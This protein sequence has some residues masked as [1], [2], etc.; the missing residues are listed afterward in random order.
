M[1]EFPAVLT[2]VF[3][4]ENRS[5]R[6]HPIIGGGMKKVTVSTTGGTGFFRLVH[7]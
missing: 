5:L 2:R 4:I 1:L 3:L 6:T 7:P